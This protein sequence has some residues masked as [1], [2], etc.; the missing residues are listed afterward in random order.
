M[1]KITRQTTPANAEK[2][3]RTFKSSMA[4]IERIS[5]IQFADADGIKI[6]LY[7]VS[8]TGKTTL[9]STFPGPIL[10]IICSGGKK[11]GELRSV[12][13]PELRRK[14]ST[15]TLENPDEATDL[16]EYQKREGKFNTLVLDHVSGLQDLTLMKI[17]GRDSLPAQKGFGIASQQ[18]WGQ[19]TGQCKEILR[20]LLSLDCN[21]VIIGQE[22]TDRPGEE[23]AGSELLKPTVGVATTPSLANWLNPA[24]DYIG[25]TFIRGKMITVKKV[26]AGQEKTY[27]KRGKGVEYCLR[28]GPHDIFTTKFRKPKGTALPE[29]IVDP[30]YNKIL[31]VIKGKPLPNGEVV[32]DAGS[33]EAE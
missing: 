25:Q 9:W 3:T 10:A 24:V 22:R 11:P 13:T 17:L 29:V 4:V 2:L 6:L 31:A 30:D 15:V 16:V 7:G 1:P 19:S 18:Q 8:G 5:P 26:V 23:D 27:M 28:T 12:N 33:E 32:E 14:I 21:V 20:A